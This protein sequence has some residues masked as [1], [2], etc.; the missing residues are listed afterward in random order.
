[1]TSTRE[2][3]L[4]RPDLAEA[5]AARDLDALAAGLNEQPETVLQPRY[6]TA[7]TILAE[8]ADGPTILAALDAA[9]ISNTAVKYA[10]QF[11]G[12]ESGLD[13]GNAVTQGM[14]DTLVPSVLTKAQADQVKG[15]AMLPQLVTRADV[16]AAM[17]NPDGTE[18]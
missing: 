3:I 8:C 13:V 12:Q 11:L 17:F 6:V 7:R 15:M 9:A 4:A 10:V 1:M 14:L 16:E 5:R 18:K 2:R